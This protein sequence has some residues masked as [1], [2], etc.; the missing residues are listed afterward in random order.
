M[1]C[2]TFNK[3]LGRQYLTRPPRRVVRRDC[4]A[5]LNRFIRQFVGVVAGTIWASL[6]KYGA[7]GSDRLNHSIGDVPTSQPFDRGMHDL[8]PSVRRNPIRQLTVR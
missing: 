7:A 3:E 5:L 6:R 1:R 8:L 4:L 2:L